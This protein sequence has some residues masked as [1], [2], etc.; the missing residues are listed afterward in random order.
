MSN[1]D[2]PGTEG[3]RIADRWSG[4]DRVVVFQGDNRQ[5][6]RAIPRETIQLIVTS[7]PY[8]VG[9]E[10]ETK[11][12]LEQYLDAQTRVIKSC[13]RVLQPDGS[14]CWQV[15]NHIAPD[16][17]V[18]PLDALLYPIFRRQGLVLRNRIIWHYGHGLHLKQRFSG[19]Y[20][21][22]LWFTH[23][24]NDYHFDLDSVRVPQKYPGK[25]HYKGPKAG[26]YSGHPNGKN[27][28]D[29]WDLSLEPGEVWDIP[30]VKAGHVEKT[31][32]P[33][34][35]PIALVTRLVRALTTPDSWV[36]DPY[37]GVGSAACAAI[38][39]GR[40]AVGAEI[41][42]EYAAVAHASASRWR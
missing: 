3:T 9:K 35:F 39:E 17:G 42:A 10:Y 30:D 20:E 32:H 41:N 11:S 21:T 6:L 36:L 22:V 28:S 5:L 27:P 13:C 18:V 15:G 19:R 8:N 1:Q 34:Q 23:N 29:F 24:T 26:E 12:S 14:L 7:P 33:C 37:L 31:Q 25:R 40:R 38:L 4:R 2:A 16:G